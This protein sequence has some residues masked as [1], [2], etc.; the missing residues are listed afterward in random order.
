MSPFEAADTLLSGYQADHNYSLRSLSRESFRH[1]SFLHPCKN[2]QLAANIEISP[3]LTLSCAEPWDDIVSYG[4]ICKLQ[5]EAST[6]HPIL[7]TLG[8]LYAIRRFY[9]RFYYI[10]VNG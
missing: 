1:V 4:Y 9:A 7:S 10:V 2:T 5:W 3:T 6:Q 8:T